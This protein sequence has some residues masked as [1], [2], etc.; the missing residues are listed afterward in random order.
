MPRRPHITSRTE[1]PATASAAVVPV[2]AAGGGVG[3]RWTLAIIAWL[4][5][6]IFGHRECPAADPK[7]IEEYE[8]KAAVASK[9][10]MFT[11]WPDA[12]FSSTSAP[13][14]I[15]ILGENRFGQHLENAV[16]NKVSVGHPLVVKQC[17]D[18]KEATQCHLVFIFGDR[19]EVEEALRQLAGL[20][21]LTV[22]DSPGFAELGGMVNLTLTPADKKIQIEVNLEAVNRS[23]LRLDPRLLQL[24][25]IVKSSSPSPKP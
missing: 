22:S 14:V 5:L 7:P 8:L 2:F 9:L 11:Q 19:K 1:P 18:I 12:S 17:R 20:K 13:L 16:R 10:P 21:V 24:A 23:G 6:L 4:L 25:K 3:S 15:G